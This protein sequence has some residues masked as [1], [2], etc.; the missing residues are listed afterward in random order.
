MATKIRVLESSSGGD[1]PTPTPIPTPSDMADIS[2]TAI[3][4]SIKLSVVTAIENA[5]ACGERSCTIVTVLPDELKSELED[6]GYRVR[7]RG[8]YRPGQ[9]DTNVYDIFW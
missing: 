3:Y 2:K 7:Q 4:D 8:I 5:A 6:S 9:I 1:T